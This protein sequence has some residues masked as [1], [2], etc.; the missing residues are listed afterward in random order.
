M[1]VADVVEGDDRRQIS[2]LITLPPVEQRPKAIGLAD[3]AVVRLADC[4]DEPPARVFHGRSLND[5]GTTAGAFHPFAGAIGRF[6]V[7]KVLTQDG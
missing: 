6:G 5:T 2:D 1:A 3:S 7:S 4:R